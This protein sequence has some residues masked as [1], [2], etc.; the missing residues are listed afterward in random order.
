MSR[1]CKDCKHRRKE[2]IGNGY[3][4]VNPYSDFLA[5]W[6]EDNWWCHD[7]EEGEENADD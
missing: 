3:I 5:N 7:W 1:T 2:S 6:V 4:C